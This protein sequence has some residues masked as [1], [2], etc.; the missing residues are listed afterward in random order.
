MWL[1]LLRFPLA[2]IG[3][4]E[5][6]K[7]GNKYIRGRH[8]EWGTVS[9][10]NESHCDFLKLREM[11][12]STNMLDLI[13]LTHS[14]HYQTYRASRLKEIGFKDEDE[15]N[16]NYMGQSKSNAKP[17]RNIQDVYVMKRDELN[18]EMQKRE[19]EIKEEFI[20]R[21]KE[22]ECEIKEQEKEVFIFGFLKLVFFVLN[23][24]LI[25]NSLVINTPN[26][27]KSKLNGWKKSSKKRES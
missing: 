2:V 4:S 24:F 5:L 19:Q 17:I 18:D 9:V 11:I 1:L 23:F 13:E 6:V 25:L 7:I 8:Y 21:V 20:K 12:L 16:E 14:K 27:K 15:A 3:S 22:K 26:G 10:E